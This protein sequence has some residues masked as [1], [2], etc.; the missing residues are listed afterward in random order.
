MT[1]DRLAGRQLALRWAYVVGWMALI[2]VL[3]AQ[4]TFPLPRMLWDDLYDIAGHLGVYGVLAVLL[5]WALAGAGVRRS[6]LWAFVLAVL[7]GISDEF[8]QSFVPGRHP[9]IF[10]VATDAV[11]AWAA[12]RLLYFIGDRMER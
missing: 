4:S 5:R 9:D 3:S 2:F 10:D 8:H 6:G 7:Y 12:L 11:G 1:R